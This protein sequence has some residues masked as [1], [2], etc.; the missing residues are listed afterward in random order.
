MYNKGAQIIISMDT[1]EAKYHQATNDIADA[2]RIY[3]LQ[4][5]VFLA[6][7]RENAPATTNTGSL[8]ND[9][10]LVGT[11]MLE[12]PCGYLRFNDMTNHRPLWMDVNQIQVFGALSAQL[13][14]PPKA[15]RLQCKDPRVV[16]KYCK[17]FKAFAHSKKIIERSFNL[18]ESIK[19][20]LTNKQEKEFERLDKERQ[21]GG[22]IAE[23][24]CRL[25][26][27][28][29]VAWF[30]KLAKAL[31]THRFWVA[32]VQRRQGRSIGIKVLRRMAR[33]ASLTDQLLAPME[34]ALEQQ[35]VSWKEYNRLKK[36]ATSLRAK[37]LDD[38]A[39]A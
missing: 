15:C 35:D 2:F 36:Q 26:K 16:K 37:W 34:T 32:L 30:P 21:A 25:L 7:G 22:E 33:Y 9:A 17:R 10:L 12:T 27:M 1:N 23:A 8:P 29:K 5:A 24:N 31:L 39:I 20:K 4:D 11:T 3:R 18:E 38:L 28:G 13:F 19:G 6:H 14:V